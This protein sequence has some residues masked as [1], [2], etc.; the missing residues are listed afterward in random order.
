M[1]ISESSGLGRDEAVMTAQSGAIAA[2]SMSAAVA[3]GTHKDGDGGQDVQHAEDTH[4]SLPA[5]R[6]ADAAEDEGSDGDEGSSDEDAEEDKK[7]ATAL[8]QQIRQ[9]EF[10]AVRTG[11]TTAAADGVQPL[12]EEG[13][14][15][16]D[17]AAAGQ[18]E[19]DHGDDNEDDDDDADESQPQVSLPPFL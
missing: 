5:H 15:S 17:A 19:K 7:A 16:A 9:A 6:D 11:T 3:H 4:A 14:P 18:H 13:A 2:A 10:V 1:H 12:L 8:G